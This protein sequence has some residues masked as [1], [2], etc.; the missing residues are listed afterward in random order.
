[1]ML[2]I[3]TTA[4]VAA[5]APHPFGRTPILYAFFYLLPFGAVF[6]GPAG[7]SRKRKITRC[8]LTL[9]VM[10]SLL[11]FLHCGGGGNS[12]GGGGPYVAPSQSGTPVGTYTVNI[13]ARSGTASRTF[14]VTLTVQ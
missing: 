8:A 12:G 6:V 9:V 7:A 3:A 14:A 2:S 10:S 4:P 11:M 5:L 1:L 13:T